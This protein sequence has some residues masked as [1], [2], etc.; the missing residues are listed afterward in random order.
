MK[1]YQIQLFVESA[2][3]GSIANAARRLGKSRS[4]VSTAI[5]A[6][7]VELGVDLFERG[8]NQSR[9]TEIGE[10]VLDDCR[11]L[12]QAANSL[13]LK[14]EHHAS[15]AEVALRVA[16][17]DAIPEP[18]W[19]EM[20]GA[21]RQQFPG[22]SIS[23]VLASPPELPALVEEGFV[24]AAFG[25]ITEDQERS[26]LN[27][28]VLNPIRTLMVVA[29]S[30]PLAGL[31]RVLQQDLT[32]QTQVTLSYVDEFSVKSLL[33]IG[34]QHIGL[35]S[36]ELRAD[37]GCSAGRPGLGGVALTADPEPAAPGRAADPEAQVQ[38]AVARLRGLSVGE[39]PSRQGAGLAE[40]GHRGLPRT[41]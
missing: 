39:R 23:L 12:L 41:L 18:V 26:G 40:E 14:C 17:D 36:F 25:L 9:L 37:A 32:D 16:R 21:L 27:I 15:G 11:R 10:Q 1:L 30:H 28:D 19:R 20:L 22:T 31:K 2:D 5:A 3:S 4:A 29:P 38:P 35:S 24:D 6:L 8:A 33:P 7:E 13:K 34:G